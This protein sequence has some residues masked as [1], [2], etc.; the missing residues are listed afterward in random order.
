V[1][2]EVGQPLAPDQTGRHRHLNSALRLPSL[3]EAGGAL[4]EADA[5]ARRLSQRVGWAFWRTAPGL[6]DMSRWIRWSRN[7][8]M[9]A[10][11][12]GHLERGTKPRNS[13]CAVD[14]GTLQRGLH[15]F[16]ETAAILNVHWAVRTGGSP[17][18]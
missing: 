3:A 9:H 4:F 17:A 7:N 16:H 10:C 5:N 8:F 1:S 11:A 6:Q 14:E 15:R 12:R 13:L 2:Y 18:A